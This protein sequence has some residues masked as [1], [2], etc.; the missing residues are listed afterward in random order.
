MKTALAI[1]LA[2]GVG[3][4]LASALMIRHQSARHAAALAAQRA[5]WEAEKA[6]LEAALAAA[7]NQVRPATPVVVTVASPAPAGAARL[8]PAEILTKLVELASG[9]AARIPT[10]QRQI[11]YWLEELVG[12]GP[13]ALPV[14]SEFL[15]RYEDLEV[16][17]SAFSGR[18]GRD[19]LPG[20][21]STPPSL[22]F[23]LFDVV[24]RI[25][26]TEAQKVLAAALSQTG[27][28]IEVAYLTRILQ[29]LAPGQHRAQALAVAHNLLAN[30]GAFSSPSPLDRN[31]RDHLFA[32]L[33]FYND[34]SFAATAQAQMVRPDGQVDRGSVRYLQQALGTQAVSMAVQAYADPRLTNAASKEVFARL[35]LNFVGADA[36]ANQFYAQTINDPSLT[37]N[38][39][40]ELIE[41]LN[42]DGF[43]DTRNLTAGDLP[44]VENRIALIEQLA[45]GALD[46]VNAAAFQEAY[47]DLVNMRAKITG[48]PATSTVLPN[49]GNNPGTRPAGQ[50]PGQFPPGP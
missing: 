23:G 31:H 13:A 11:I 24:R 30:S 4:A 19:R 49:V 6:E 12:N 50:A 17:P 2:A 42:Q 3:F 27:R 43:P 28:G 16:D 8:T 34:A 26:G 15:G 32:V 44:L 20:D 14:V 46:K 29:E 22:R 47:K 39:H 36:Q 45:P 33:A 7:K 10:G 1:L 37:P 35:A 25:G 41:D 9:P 40:R 38:H 21:F 5:A 18:G 48:Q